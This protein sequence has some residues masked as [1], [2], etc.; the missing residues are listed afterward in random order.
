MDEEYEIFKQKQREA[1]KG[2]GL[3]ATGRIK[4]F[5]SSKLVLVPVVIPSSVSTYTCGCP[6][7]TP[8]LPI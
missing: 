7:V 2:K 6:T 3:L 5:Y 4:K 1:L 8:L